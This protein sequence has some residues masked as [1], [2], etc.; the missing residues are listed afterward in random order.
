MENNN[1]LDH[2]LKI[3]AEAAALVSD[4][5]AEA[6]R[7]IRNNEEKC[8]SAYEDKFRERTKTL[9]AFLKNDED[10]IKKQYQQ[11][12]EDY[13]QEISG[14]KVDTESF[15]ILLNK[16]LAGEKYGE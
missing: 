13:R 6:D 5:Q 16:Y 2:L 15:S 3:E 11:A 12:L 14:I 10:K 7:R 1:T 9:D 4:A 8:R